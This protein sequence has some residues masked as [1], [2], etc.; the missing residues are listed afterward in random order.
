LWGDASI[1]EIRL[2]SGKSGGVM[3]VQFFPASL[4]TCARPS[5]DPTQMVLAS[6]RDG[7]T[8]KIVGYVSTPVWSNAIGPPD[9]PIVFGS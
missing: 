1:S 8:V 4:V 9:G 6:R 7:A 5:S 3:F 2:N